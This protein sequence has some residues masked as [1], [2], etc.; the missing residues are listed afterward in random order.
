M[1]WAFM[2]L[3]VVSFFLGAGYG[4]ALALRCVS[5][6]ITNMDEG[7]F[8]QFVLAENPKPSARLEVDA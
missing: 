2:L 8:R 5:R 3:I 1:F 6:R 7:E 4:W